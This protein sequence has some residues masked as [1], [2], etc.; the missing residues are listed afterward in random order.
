VLQPEQVVNARN[1]YGGTAKE[2]VLAAIG[3]AESV[4]AETNAWVTEYAERSK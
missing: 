4:L 2:Q 3:R 1:V